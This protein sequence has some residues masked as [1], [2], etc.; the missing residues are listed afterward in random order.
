MPKLAFDN[1]VGDLFQ[2]SIEMIEEGL[3]ASRE[4]ERKRIILPIHRKQEAEVQRL[5]N[6]LQ[7]GTYIRPHKHPLDHA[8]ESIVLLKGSIRF[9]TFDDDGEVLTDQ[10]ISSSPIPGVLDMEPNVWH[11][12][13]VLEEDTIL[14]ECKK[15]PYNAE[16]DKEFAEWAPSE[17]HQT[18]ENWLNKLKG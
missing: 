18:V 7:P 2:L 9:F 11:S 15:G 10:I 4:R 13:L 14:F 16:T 5:V 8:T 12:F 3:E 17:R 6:F 1:P